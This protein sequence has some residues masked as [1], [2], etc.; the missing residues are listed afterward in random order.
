MKKTLSLLAILLATAATSFA[1]ETTKTVIPAEDCRFRA[2]EW[3][4]DLSTVGQVGVYSNTGKQGLGGNL[5]INYFFSK[6]FG[7]GFDNSVGG[8]RNAGLSGLNGMQ[9]YYNLQGD[10]LARYPICSWNLSPY[11]MVG[12]GGLWGPYSQGDG[13]VGGGL[14]Y[15]FNQNVGVFADCRWL[16]GTGLSMAL[17]RVGLRFAF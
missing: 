4:V 3:Q 7:V 16:F 10:L 8:Q 1:G 9:G 5:G 15:R 17:P 11:I 6:Y 2:N 13:N 12:G 14:E